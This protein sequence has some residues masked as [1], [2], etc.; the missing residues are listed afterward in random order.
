[1]GFSLSFDDIVNYGITKSYVGKA[2]Y[3]YRQGKSKSWKNFKDLRDK[4]KIWIDVDTIPEPTRQ[5]YNIPTA[6][7]YFEQRRLAE[8][9]KLQKIEEKIQKEKELRA[10]AE[11]SALHD[12][13][14]NE[15]IPFLDIYEGLYN[16][17]KDCKEL[18]ILSAREH[19]FWTKMLEI[20]GTRWATYNGGCKKGFKLYMEL[21]GDLELT[22]NF[23]NEN[24]FR[25]LITKMRKLTRHEK[26]IS[27]VVG[28]GLRLKREKRT[29]DFHKSTALAFL[30]H[31]NKYSYRIVTDLVNYHCIEEN[32]KPIS[33]SWI[34]QLMA[35][36]NHFRTL[37][38]QIRNG[39]KYAKDNIIMHAVRKNTPFPANIWM[40]DGSPLQFYCWNENR[41]KIIRL[42]LFVIIDVCSRKIVGFDIS[43]SETRFNIMNALK[44]AVIEEGHLPAEIVSDNF[45]AIKTEEIKAMVEQM[46]NLGTVWRHAKVGNPQ[47]KSYVE[48]F[49]GAF[50]SVECTLFDDYIGEGIMSKR[51]NRRT[52]EQL[53]KT[54]KKDGFPSFS[55]MKDRVIEMI[56]RYNAR[57]KANAK[58]PKVIYSSLPKP[59]AVEMDIVRTALLFWKRTKATVRKSMI[60]I[61]VNKVEHFFEVND[62]KISTELQGKRV[63]V[64]YDEWDLSHIMIF[65]LRHEKVICECKKAIKI[66]TGYVDRTEEDLQNMYKVT[67][68]QK[69]KKAYLEN[70]RNKLLQKA[71]EYTDKESIDL[72]HP[73]SLAKNKLTELDDLAQQERLRQMLNISKEDEIEPQK[74]PLMTI[75]KKGTET[76]YADLIEEKKPK[77]GFKISTLADVEK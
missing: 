76:D 12:A 59:N 28:N 55:Q 43:Y 16:Y 6:E 15:Y 46:A 31:P 44:M 74:E 75:R 45:S 9:E 36:D 66:A 3:L 51:D 37:V 53:L 34:K 19:A 4:R 22:K 61:V 70:E 39:E 77:K 52:A 60:K 38:M 41:N 5:K 62:H 10:N 50:Q 30:S 13:Y 69:S 63:F 11:K 18:A 8:Q 27:E 24:Y 32:Q 73:R 40:L 29:T 7:E 2:T 35:T 48:R 64:R 57:E 26:C 49:F 14:H 58:A 21:K 1:M 56:V 65:D 71:F 17:H 67:A 42:N 72:I 20:T 23:T 54:S 47:D 25:I 33:E 68:K